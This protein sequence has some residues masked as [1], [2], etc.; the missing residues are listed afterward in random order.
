MRAFV[1]VFY[2]RVF[3]DPVLAPIFFDVAQIDTGHHLALI[4]AYWEKLLLGSN[5][6]RRHT[7]NIH[8]ALHARRVLQEQD[9]E[10]WLG[11][12]RAALDEGFEGRGADRAW[13]IA[14][15]VARNMRAAFCG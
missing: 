8:R 5:E 11:H 2:A 3:A 6:Y 7:M 1:D 4:R 14:Q 12:F 15:H 9:F 10:R 13:Q